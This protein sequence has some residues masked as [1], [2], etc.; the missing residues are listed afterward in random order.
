M[1]Y[2]KISTFIPVGLFLLLQGYL[3]FFKD[4]QVLDYP[5]RINEYPLPLSGENKAVE[6]GFRT[7]GPLA[8]IDMMLAN[9]KVKPGGGTL[10]LSIFKGD[11]RLFLKNYPAN[12]VEDNRFY[13]FKIDPGRITRGI[14]RL[15]LNYFPGP[16]KEQLAAWINKKNRCPFGD[17]YS[18]GKKIAGTATFR[19]YYLA[20]IWQE[21][22]R[23]LDQDPSQV[24]APR[25]WVR[26]YAALIS[27]I[28]LVF[29]VNL[30]FY[31]FLGKLSDKS[32]TNDRTNQRHMGI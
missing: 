26:G 31:Y 13:S 20:T 24:Q 15:R 27:F 14:Y 12:I 30:L 10:R 7:S 17:L 28:L 19:V 21:R 6:Q 5:A 3:F 1:I 25:F 9:Y 18:N 4:F 8:R 11:R 29:M 22:Q 2:K 23:W 16:G 32:D